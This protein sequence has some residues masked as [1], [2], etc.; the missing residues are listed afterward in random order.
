M[1]KL[2]YFQKRIVV[3]TIQK[4]KDNDIVCVESPTGS[5]KSVMITAAVNI[6]LKKNLGSILIIV[7]T[8]QIKQQFK[9]YYNLENKVDIFCNSAT[10]KK[11]YDYIF[12]DE[13]HHTQNGITYRD[14]ITNNPK[15]KIIL[16]SATFINNNNCIKNIVKEDTDYEI[17][18]K[19]Y[20]SFIDV[21][22][23]LFNRKIDYIKAE[24]N[25]KELINMGYLSKYEIIQVEDLTYKEKIINFLDKNE[26]KPL[27]LEQG[28]IDLAISISKDKLIPIIAKH[29]KILIFGANRN[30]A[31][32]IYNY[33]K[34]QQIDK[35]VF[36]FISNLK[37][38][39]MEKCLN[40]IELF[41]KE[42]NC[43]L[44]A[45]N[46]ANEG[47]DIPDLDCAITIRHY[48][49]NKQWIQIVGRV[50]RK[51]NKY[52]KKYIYDM[53]YNLYR[54]G[55]P[56]DDTYGIDK[57]NIIKKVIKY[58]EEEE[59][60]RN[61]CNICK[62]GKYYR[63]PEKP[64]ICKNKEEIIKSIKGRIKYDTIKDDIDYKSKLFKNLKK[65]YKNFFLDG[66]YLPIN[67][68]YFEYY[69]ECDVCHNQVKVIK[70][71]TYKNYKYLECISKRFKKIKNKISVLDL[72]KQKNKYLQNGEN[73][74]NI[75]TIE[76]TKF[77]RNEKYNYSLILIGEK[78]YTFKITQKN[79]N[80][81]KENSENIFNCLFNNKKFTDNV[82]NINFIE[83]LFLEKK[84]NTL[85]CK[86]KINDSY[87]LFT[88]KKFKILR[89]IIK[90]EKQVL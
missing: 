64:V 27:N 22:K 32:D 82:K 71:I 8:K 90:K 77:V 86:K 73:E 4:I 54:H 74:I 47:L 88:S 38:F 28:T 70:P 18:I 59:E 68:E 36:L 3:K 29:N 50:I 48:N 52:E 76:T 62:K 45:V 9:K 24:K 66:E 58:E 34:Q 51:S 60:E 75:D 69:K 1:E 61:I 87:Y 39:S 30:H 5:G 7:P 80:F 13:A 78:T 25:I 12:I 55:D 67:T 65:Y 53:G 49:S 79:F 14:I 63:L 2:R 72:I 26:D 42:N 31:V 85:F 57:E 19:R 16:C 33:L 21:F 41:K 81:I 46:G 37:Q 35:K 17:L 11:Q 44:I 56:I 23:S 40:D 10:I 83:N 84:Q 6:I 20:P 15:S 89:Y 43:V